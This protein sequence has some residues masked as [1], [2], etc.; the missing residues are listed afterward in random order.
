MIASNH[1]DTYAGRQRR[2]DLCITCAAHDMKLRQGTGISL[3]DYRRVKLLG[4]TASGDPNRGCEGP[5]DSHLG[6]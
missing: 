5:A 1:I 4:P 2:R 3:I 6:R